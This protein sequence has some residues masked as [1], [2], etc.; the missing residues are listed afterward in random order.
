M[1]GCGF[2]IQFVDNYQQLNEGKVLKVFF[3]EIEYEL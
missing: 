2:W 3:F 1:K